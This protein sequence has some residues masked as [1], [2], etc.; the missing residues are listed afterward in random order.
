MNVSPK[1]EN[2]DKI[3][4]PP[5]DPLGGTGS[6]QTSETSKRPRIARGR[7]TRTYW[8]LQG[9]FLIKHDI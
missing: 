7:I 5:T 1:S 4:D 6:K 2:S 3:L 8:Q 9:V